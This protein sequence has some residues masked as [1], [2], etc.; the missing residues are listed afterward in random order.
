[1]WQY[2]DA[3]GLR[4]ALQPGGAGAQSSYDLLLGLRG[5]AATL[6]FLNL[7]VPGQPVSQLPGF[8]ERVS[9][10]G[11]TLGLA[12]GL[13]M[14]DPSTRYGIEVMTGPSIVRFQSTAHHLP[15]PGTTR[16]ELALPRQVETI[17]RRKF[18]RAPVHMAV[19]FSPGFGP[20]SPCAGQGGLGHAL[21]LSAGGLRFIT[22]T[23]LKFGDRLYVS[24]NTP[25]GSA[26]RGLAAKVV[27]SQ[28]DGPRFTVSMQFTDLDSDVENQ[29]VQT[30]V[31]LQLGGPAKR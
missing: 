3:R 1:M 14:H 22:Q 17:Q 16:L 20:D 13:P 18:S 4:H 5:A 9:T 6:L 11:V 2:G 15:D 12:A 31:R 7:T 19:A 21:D 23:P 27:R 10:S 30:V 8:I 29:L 28:P 25:D 24:F 26:F